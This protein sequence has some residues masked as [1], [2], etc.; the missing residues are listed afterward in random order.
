[1][2]RPQT[3]CR[4]KV[5]QTNLGDQTLSGTTKFFFFLYICFTVYRKP[6][7]PFVA[8]LPSRGPLVASCRC[9]QLVFLLRSQKCC[10][11]AHG[12]QDSPHHRLS[13]YIV[14]EALWLTG[15]PSV[16]NKNQWQY[17]LFAARQFLDFLF[18]MPIVFLLHCLELCTHNCGI[19]STRPGFVFFPP[20]GFDNCSRGMLSKTTE[21]LEILMGW[22][23]P[24]DLV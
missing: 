19:H 5:A 22:V 7:S 12:V 9:S 17:S 21:S 3:G 4:K 20:K 24:R 11:P 18:H 13:Q 10:W 23:T 16:I 6:S 2:N 15:L 14:T 1:M 8:V